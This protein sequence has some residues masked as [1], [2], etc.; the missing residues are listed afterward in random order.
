MRIVWVP[1]EPFEQRYTQDWFDWFP[2]E[3]RALGQEYLTIAPT[4]LL[5]DHGIRTGD[6]LDVFGTSTWKLTQ[7]KEIVGLWEDGSLRNDDVFLFADLWF[8]GIETLAYMRAFKPGPKI[9]GIMH[10]GSYDHQD[11]TVRRGMQPWAHDVEQAWLRIVDKVFVGTVYH[12]NLL[13]STHAVP[14][15]TDYIIERPDGTRP[16]ATKVAV[17]G[18]PFYTER[19]AEEEWVPL[20]ERGKSIVF[21]HRLDPEKAPEVFESLLQMLNGRGV[22]PQSIKTAEHFSTK[23]NYME[24]LGQCRVAFSSA[25][26]ETFGYAMLEAVMRGCVP[27]VPNRLAYSEMYHPRFRYDTMEQAAEMVEEAFRGDLQPPPTSSLKKWEGAIGD[28]VVHCNRLVG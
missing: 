17:T 21:P 10:A 18:L 24:T 4:H 3:F 15:Q 7:L 22:Y 11:F 9:T 8:P 28:M 12:Q 6:V 27:I 5:G 13:L 19:W 1:L 23:G 26:Q 16:A 25:R 14:L 20:A 2:K